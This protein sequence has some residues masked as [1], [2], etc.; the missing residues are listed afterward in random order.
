MTIRRKLL[1]LLVLTAVIPAGL[2]GM[3]AYRGAE[4]ALEHA[5]MEQHVRTALAEAEFV[6]HYLHSLGQGLFSAL[7]H[8]DPSRLT[9][10][11]TQEYLMRLY[12]RSDRI[13]LVG[14]FDAQRQMSASVFVDDADRFA[15]QEP[16]FRQHDVI[17]PQEVEDFQRRAGELL[18]S[19]PRDRPY[20]FSEPYLTVT[21]QRPAL[22]VAGLAPSARGSSLVVELSLEELSRRLAVGGREGDRIFLLDRAGRLLLDGDPEH[23]RRREDYSAR[24]PPVLGAPRAGTTRFQEGDRWW[25]AAFNPVPEL[26][27]MAVVSRPRE[28]ALAPL[29]ALLRAASSVLALAVL[30]VLALVPLLARALARPIGQLAEGARQLAQGNLGHRLSLRRDDELGD[31]ARGFNQMAQQLQAT[32][33]Q[34]IFADRLA[35]MG[36]TAA[37]VAHEINNPLTYLLGNLA[38]LQEELSRPREALPEKERQALLEA[39][40]EAWTGAER[41]RF[42]TQDLKMLSRAEETTVGPVRLDAVVRSSARMAAH[43]LKNRARVVEDCDGV[44]PVQG[45]AARLG[46]VF[47]NLI[48]NAAHAIAPGRAEENEIRVT[49][50][51]GEPGRVTVDVSDTGCGIAPENLERIFDLFFTTKPA[52]E[53]TGIGLA[54][55]RDIVTSLGGSITVKSQLGRGTTFHLTLPAAPSTP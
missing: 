42:I 49:A 25:L 10:S 52:G 26:G 11:E 3:L 22:L 18:A 17:S 5:V 50:R 19:A 51:L 2:T 24:L 16:Q 32:Q 15:R 35:T 36:R 33:A 41:V 39:A 30:G 6:T 7:V 8:T 20:I 37:G 34:L 29:S 14:L 23:E 12:L 40:T 54:M 47:L 43:E 46:Q 27:W 21:R 1:L 31:M 55:C 38:W 44:P 45:N 28:A 53:G 4:V 9:P 48:I 13:C